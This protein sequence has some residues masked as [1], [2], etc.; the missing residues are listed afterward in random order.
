MQRDRRETV[1]AYNSPVS[2]QRPQA[3]LSFWFCARAEV[4]KLYLG[5]A[6]RLARQGLH[7]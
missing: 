4:P 7:R 3:R 2:C 6:A 1:T 5:A